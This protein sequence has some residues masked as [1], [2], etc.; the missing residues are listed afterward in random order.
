M[1]AADSVICVAWG[2]RPLAYDKLGQQRGLRSGG[3]GPE[4]HQLRVE[5]K[6]LRLS[7]AT[8]DKGRMDASFDTQ[9]TLSI[10]AA[11]LAGRRPLEVVLTAELNRSEA[12]AY[13][14]FVATVPSGHYRQTRAW[15]GTAVHRPLY[16]LARRGAAVIGAALVQ[17]VRLAGL[18]LPFAQVEHGP[19][20]AYP[21]D[22]PDVLAALRQACRGCGIV[23]LAVTPYWTDPHRPRVEK[24]LAEAGFIPHRRLPP[25]TLRLDLAELDD[26][27]SWSSRPLTQIRREIGRAARA[28]VTVRP[29]RHDDIAALAPAEG[30]AFREA[31]E[32]VLGGAG[33]MFV[34]AFE[35]AP[36]AAVFVTL[37]NGLATVVG[38]V[39]TPRPLPFSPSVLALTEAV[40]WARR[41]GARVFDMDGMEDDTAG[42]RF[43][44]SYCRTQTL[45]VRPH[46][47][48]F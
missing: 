2:L 22:L 3:L 24:M 9:D 35:G 44:Q 26:I 11:V 27:R 40:Q 25:R 14:Q 39:S 46:V 30:A 43:D 21:G 29:G 8:Q 47:R 1:G 16:F 34:A 31:G 18:A 33:A 36:I 6:A 10:L 41:V 28:G 23:R 4:C 7:N 13:D 32:Y 20:T 48:W 5:P 15:A 12:H 38:G 42:T 37:H 45:L 19:V 17:R